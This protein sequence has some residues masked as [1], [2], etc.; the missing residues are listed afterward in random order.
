MLMNIKVT[1]LTANHRARFCEPKSWV[2]QWD[3]GFSVQCSCLAFIKPSGSF[4]RLFLFFTIVFRRI[5]VR[6]W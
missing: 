4:Y 1:T 3:L 6:K 2:M 5:S